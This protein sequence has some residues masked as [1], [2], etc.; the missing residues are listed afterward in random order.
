LLV[1]LADQVWT[2]LVDPTTSKQH[3]GKKRTNATSLLVAVPVV[4]ALERVASAPSNWKIP[5]FEATGVG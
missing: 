2:E 4:A 5:L 3:E 1:L